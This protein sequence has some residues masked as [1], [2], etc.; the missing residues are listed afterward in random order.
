MDTAMSRSKRIAAIVAGAVVVVLAGAAIAAYI[1][2]REVREYV[3]AALGPQGSAARIDVGLTAIA[4]TDVRLKAPAGW[5]AQDAL[6]A[7]HV[8]IVTDLRDLMARRLHV[9]EVTVSGFDLTVRRAPDGRIELL[10]GLRQTLASPGDAAP[11]SSE[12]DT[13]PREKRIDRIAFEDGTF[14]FYDE[15]VS[16]PAWHIA[17]TNARAT[18]GPLHFPALAEPSNVNVTGAIRGPSH[19]GTLS[20]AGWI[21]LANRDSQTTTKLAGVDVVRFAPYLLKKVGTKTQIAAG[22]LD[23]SVEAS[24]RNDQLR[25]P[26]TITLHHLELADTGDPLDTFLS[27][28]TKAAVAALKRRHDDITLH[29]VLAG[30]LHDPKFSLNENLMTKMGSGFAS[31]LG[32][33]VEGVAKGV[34]ETAKGLGGTLMNLLGQ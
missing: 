21:A 28:P 17:V 25:A 9:R 12:E 8:T 26:G 27:I 19:T 3:V 33:S 20:F 4:L 10:P 6:R 1:A 22:T 29:F 5:P 32:V 24:V 15:S 7:A 11:T 31:A 2:E 34:G 13:L 30:N 18:V 23:A 14:D 16:R